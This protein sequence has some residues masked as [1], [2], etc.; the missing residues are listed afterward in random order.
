MRDLPLTKG[1]PNLHDPAIHTDHSVGFRQLICPET[2][3]LLGTEV[4]VDDAPPQW[5]IRPGYDDV[6]DRG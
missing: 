2:G 3:R 6:T 5:D 1:N 4:V